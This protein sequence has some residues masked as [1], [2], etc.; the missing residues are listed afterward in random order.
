MASP[1]M[2]RNIIFLDCLL[3]YIIDRQHTASII[4]SNVDIFRSTSAEVKMCVC[5]HVC[6]KIIQTCTRQANNIILEGK[7]LFSPLSA[8]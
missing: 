8:Q 7:G 4:H 6:V 2:I 3:G 1:P 5:V